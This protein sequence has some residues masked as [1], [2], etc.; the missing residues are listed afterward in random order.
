MK[1]LFIFFCFMPMAVCAQD[2]KAEFQSFKAK[3]DHFIS[4][5]DGKK[6]APCNE[7]RLQYVVT[8]EQFKEEVA[9]PAQ[10]NSLCDDIKAYEGRPG[11]DLKAVSDR[12]YVIRADKD[13]GA[14][15]FYYYMRS[16][17]KGK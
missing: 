8:G 14:Q 2:A 10:M 4:N 6:P 15:E 1:K 12:Y 9:K 17:Y 3:L 7:Y 5:P 16:P 11:Y 13:G